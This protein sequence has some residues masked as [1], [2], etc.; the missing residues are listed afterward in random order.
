VRRRL[1]PSVVTTAFRRSTLAVLAAIVLAGL[2]LRID[3]GARGLPYLNH[4]DEPFLVHRAIVMIETRDPN[5]RFFDYGTLR[6]Y[7]DAVAGKFAGFRL[8]RLPASHPERLGPEAP[9]RFRGAIEDP[10]RRD[11]GEL[12]PWWTSHPSFFRAA[13]T[14]SA[15]YGALTILLAAALAR[16]L[17]GDLAALAAAALLAFD[18]LHVHHSSLATVDVL[19][20]TTALAALWAT[21]RFRDRRRPADLALAFV[22]VGLTASAKYNIAIVGFA[23]MAAALLAAVGEPPRL[24]RR[25]LISGPALAAVTFALTT[26]FALL[27]RSTFLRDIGRVRRA[28]LDRQPGSF[29]YFEPGWPHLRSDLLELAA[30]LSLPVALLAIAGLL[31]LLRRRRGGWVFAAGAVL[32]ALNALTKAPFHRNLLLLYPLAAVAGGIAAAGARRLTALGPPLA[33]PGR[34]RAGAAVVAVLGAAGA[35]AL[36]SAAFARGRAAVRPTPRS[37]A[38]AELARRADPAAGPIAVARELALH[39][40]DRARW[41][42]ELIEQPLDEILCAP[43]AAVAFLVPID[44]VGHLP[45]P[46]LRAE[47]LSRLLEAA[48]PVLWQRGR[49]P[50]PL[51][52]PSAFAGVALRAPAAPPTAENGLCDAPARAGG[53]ASRTVR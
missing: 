8:G 1:A 24:A 3:R 36:G 42:G 34:P 4:W 6:I 2:A 44:V 12:P 11:A 17:G 50:L 14:M 5:P 26:P 41:P 37:Q 47:R 10:L 46:A 28:Y 7:L 18:R 13:R 27:D 51:D 33:L 43:G 53:S 16:S 23:P 21:Q 35:L 19:A 52:R 15:L 48:G 30:N 31:L 49:A 38:L 20:T 45:E 9:V 29:L 25:W 32:V 39:P 22:A 40:L